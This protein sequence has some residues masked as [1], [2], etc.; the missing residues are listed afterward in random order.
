MLKKY[1]TKNISLYGTDI[2]VKRDEIK[3]YFLRTYELYEKLYDIFV[4]NSVYY[5]QPE[6]LRHKLIFYFGHTATF[7]INKLIIGRYIQNRVNPTYESI[8]AIGVDEMSWDD[9]N[10][11]NYNWPDVNEVK[12]YRT[13]VKQV[14][15]E[16]IENCDFTLPINWDSPM[17]VILMG[18]E[19]ERIHL[20]TSSVLHRQLDIKYVKKSEIFKEYIE[21]KNAPI[22]ELLFVKGSLVRLG[23][24]KKSDFYGWDNEYGSYMHEVEDFKASKYLV[25]N[26]EFMD[27]VLDGGYENDEYWSD[28]GLRWRDYKQ[29]KHPHF[30]VQDGN[31]YKYRT[32]TQIVDMPWSYPVEVNFLEAEA[33]CKYLSKKT[34]KNIILPSEAQWHRLSE[35][36]GLEYN[37]DYSLQG[38]ANINLEYNC[39]S[40]SVDKFAHG[41]FFD[42]IGNVW[43]W[44]TTP[45]DQFTGFE[46]HPLY[47]DFSVPT[48]DTRHNIIKGGSWIS[49]G[50]EVL[51]SSRYAFRRHF[52]QHAGFR[53]IEVEQ[54]ILN[55]HEIEQGAFVLEEQKFYDEVFLKLNE[56]VNLD[57]IKNVL[58]IGCFYGGLVFD[59]H[60]ANKNIA[61]T[62]IDFTARNIM[63]AQ[64]N[65]DTFRYENIEFWQGDSCNLKK[66]FSGYDLI[67]LTNSFNEIYSL[68]HMIDDLILKLN[69]NGK[70]VFAFKSEFDQE[71]VQK[72]INERNIESYIWQ[73]SIN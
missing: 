64:K 8:F 46:V 12:E 16:Y 58:N 44:T 15:L 41:D 31:N 3:E 52:F 63:I 43:Q 39:S 14:V 47:D 2:E 48:F 62:G 22:N 56:V 10:N 23:R 50:N 4:D 26:Q 18:I 53:Y 66:H 55:A 5:T 24:D 40:V 71:L 17:W 54:L 70:L 25:S 30:W 9:L 60:K 69:P 35:Y 45:I 42:V 36:C 6:P 28:E 72:Y 57:T 27:F 59:I 7:Y 20:E 38:I 68:D 29:V 19:H 49:T 13:K 1:L 21:Y 11:S 37:K 73:I 32:M 67:I 65:L 34:N 51:L 33:F 61:I